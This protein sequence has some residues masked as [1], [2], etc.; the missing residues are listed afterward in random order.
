LELVRL[1]LV[2]DLMKLL[3][4]VLG[5]ETVLGRKLGSFGIRKLEKLPNLDSPI[6]IKPA[7]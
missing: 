6:G 1:G 4:P 5:L 3:E 7:A 2:F